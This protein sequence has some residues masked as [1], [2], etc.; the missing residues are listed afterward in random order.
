MG[1]NSRS[2]LVLKSTTRTS[3]QKPTKYKVVE[4]R[5]TIKSNS[6]GHLVLKSTM[7]TIVLE[8][9]YYTLKSQIKSI[10]KI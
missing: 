10:C 9:Y 7:R 1:S 2:N 4:E 5:N 6:R 3:V 8:T